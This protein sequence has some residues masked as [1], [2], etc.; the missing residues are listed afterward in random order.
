[1][2]DEENK[3]P[4]H[5]LCVG[6]LRVF[7]TER[8]LPARRSMVSAADANAVAAA[9]ANTAAAAAAANTAAAATAAA[10]AAAAAAVAVDGGGC[11]SCGVVG[12]DLTDEQS[13]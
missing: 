10:A 13:S 6:L 5:G 8:P 4:P 1:M 11:D 9:A 2:V 3:F 12:G 7:A